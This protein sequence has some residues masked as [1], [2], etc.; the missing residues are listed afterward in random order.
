V[1]SSGEITPRT[2]VVAFAFGVARAQVGD[3]VPGPVL[4]RLLADLGVSGPAA[5]SLVLRMRREGWLTSER[6]GRE[7]RYRLAPLTAAAQ[8]RV[9]GQLR[10]S[11]PGWDGS[12]SGV[13]F[14]VPE[15]HR[16]FRDRLRRSAQLL[17]Y[18][19]LRPGLLI[20]AT[21]RYEELTGLLPPRPAGSQVLRT[22]LAFSPEDTRSIV[23][24]L[25]DLEGLAARYRAVLADAGRRTSRAEK[26]PAAGAAAFRNFAAATLPL[27]QASADDPDL[28]DELLPA[29][30]P[31]QQ[32]G[33]ALGRA[34]RAFG[35][36]LGDYLAAVAGP[37]AAGRP[38]RPTDEFAGERPS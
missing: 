14:S 1:A 24:Q 21:D 30:W 4:I 13:L 32:V 16:S 27:Y 28:P 31:G 18:V 15:R 8:A 38:A 9:E 34:F 23:P 29:G 12:F 6:A 5:R 3:A 37:S 11:R 36:A 33:Q 26:Q 20:A 10:G 35:P 22:R 25:W 7:A 19:T 17:G 2:G